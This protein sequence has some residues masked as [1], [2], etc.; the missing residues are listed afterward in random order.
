MLISRFLALP[1][2][3]RAIVNSGHFNTTLLKSSRARARNLRM[4]NC[5]HYPILNP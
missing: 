1:W 2:Y 3:I 5:C 4:S